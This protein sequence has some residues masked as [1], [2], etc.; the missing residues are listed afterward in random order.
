MHHVR[1]LAAVVA[2]LALFGCHAPAP[3]RDPGAI[4]MV[5]QLG[6]PVVLASGQSTVYARLRVSAKAL[7]PAR[8]RGPI[9]VVLCIDTSGSMEGT[10]IDETRKAALGMVDAL[11][12]GDRL[13]VVVFNTRVETLLGPSELDAAVRSDVAERIRA[14]K[15]EG[16]TDLAGGLR[17]AISMVE[18]HYEKNGVNRIV[19]L[20]DGIPN[21]P[22]GIQYTVEQA[23]SSGV[24]ITTVGLGLDYDEA[25]MGKIAQLS[26]GRFQYVASADKVL[27]FFRDEIERIDAV[28]GRRATATMT[29]GPGV[30]ID[31]VV[32]T[33][34]TRGS[35]S[36]SLALGDIARGETRDI[37][38]RLT[39]TPRKEGVPIE[40]LDAH[41]T[42][43]DALADAG[44]LDRR[45]YLGARTVL[46]PEE[47]AKARNTEVELSAGLAEAAA[48]TIEGLALSKR[49]LYKSAR[50]VLSKGSQA[51]LDQAK[52]TPSRELEKNAADMTQVAKDL[53][54]EDKP[55]PEPPAAAPTP[56][57]SGYDF[58]EE[59]LEMPAMQAAQPPAAQ[60]RA[61]EVHKHAVDAFSAH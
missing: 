15:A 56:T 19:L 60:M 34:S 28:Y 1:L 30:T 2:A 24:A 5:G 16:T 41:V 58:H 21:D 9:N 12:D 36:A 6:T 33:P 31:E 43:D 53:P 4:T 14:L 13:A 27:P 35:R 59:H 11:A 49:G 45:V 48:A 39:V 10:P 44:I 37:V 7:P 42:F 61:K 46:E 18:S 55:V 38:V 25:L 52:R 29:A 50:E 26:G 22:S 32:G 51:A 54:N 47:V 23:A 40:L 3:P 20:G 8:P 17:E 57:S